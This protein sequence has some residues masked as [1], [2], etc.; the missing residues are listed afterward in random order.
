MKNAFKSFALAACI[1]FLSTNLAKS[2][3][4]VENYTNCD[5]TL[6]VAY[7]DVAACQVVGSVTMTV[8]AHHIEPI[9]ILDFYGPIEVKGGYDTGSP[10]LDCP[11]YVTELCGGGTQSQAITCSLQCL[12][13]S[14]DLVTNQGIVINP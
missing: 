7:G 8:R 10:V 1:I 11:F 13:Y 9:P 12:N 14:V 3:N 2:Q 4:M 6:V 5:I